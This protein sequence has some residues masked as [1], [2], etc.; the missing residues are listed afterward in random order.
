MKKT[1]TFK[2]FIKL[3]FME[4]VATLFSVGTFYIIN[5]TPKLETIPTLS[6]YILFGKIAFIIPLVFTLILGMFELP[7]WIKNIGKKEKNMTCIKSIKNKFLKWIKNIWE[8]IKKR[9]NYKTTEITSKPDSE[10][11]KEDK[12]NS[13][14]SIATALMLGI[15][16]TSFIST[17]GNKVANSVYNIIGMIKNNE[18]D[19]LIDQLIEDSYVPLTLIALSY[20]SL[21]LLGLLYE[22]LCDSIMGIYKN[23]KKATSESVTK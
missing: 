5:L 18:I 19:Q 10:Q 15:F 7:I 3:I 12:H 20:P 6:D 17:L 13:N 8:C 22:R 1:F 2:E 23:Y 4:L 9:E 21:Y 11:S 16:A 14:S